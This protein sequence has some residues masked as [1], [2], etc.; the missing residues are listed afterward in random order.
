M[1]GSILATIGVLIVATNAPLPTSFDD[2][3]VIELFAAEPDIVTPTAIS[4]DDKGNPLVIECHTHFRPAGYEGPVADRLRRFE[5]TNCDG[6]ADRITTFWEGST[7][8]MGIGRHPMNGWTYVATRDCVFR[9]RDADGDGSAE[10]HE[11]LVTL[12]SADKYP[13]S[14]ISGLAFN[15]EGAVFFCFGENHAERFQMKGSDGIALTGIEGGHIYRMMADGS[16]LERVAIGCWNP[17]HLAFDPAGRL[18]TVDNDPDAL[19]PC[20]LLHIVD[21]GD[22]GYKYRN[23]RKGTHPFTAWNGELPGTL[24]MVAGTGEAPSGICACGMGDRMPADYRGDLL[25]TSWGDHRIERYRL[26]PRGAS[27]AAERVNLVTGDENFRPVGIVAG[28]DGALY[29][30]DWVDKSYELHKKGRIWRLRTIKPGD[31]SQPPG[32]EPSKSAEEQRAE[33]LRTAD[34]ATRPD[35]LW[36]ACEE[37]DP[38]IQ[39]A[40]RKG[41]ARVGAVVPTIQ[42]KS[43]NRGQ[44][45]AAA[46]ILRTVNDA[47]SQSR[48]PEFLADPDP[49]LRFVALQWA[50]EEK[51]ASCRT[52]LPEVLKAG[53]VTMRLFTGYL[54]ACEKLDRSPRKDSD[55]WTSDQYLADAYRD[56]HLPPELE[57]MIVRM[58]PPDHAV[59][60]EWRKRPDPLSKADLPNDLSA[61]AYIRS[62]ADASNGSTD[63]LATSVARAFLEHAADTAATDRPRLLPE[64]VVGLHADTPARVVRL[65]RLAEHKD[66]QVVVEALKSLRGA[67]LDAEQLSRIRQSAARSR[68]LAELAARVTDSTPPLSIPVDGNL[69]AWLKLLDGPANA[70]AGERIF[71]HPKAAQ[72]GRCHQVEGRG[73][74]IGPDLTLTGR[75]L[76]RRR[77]VESILQPSKEI[78]PQFANWAIQTK[79]GQLLTGMLVAET[80]KGEHRY[81]DSQGNIVTLNPDAIESRKQ[82][83]TSIMPE[84]LANQ[85]TPQEFRDLVA[86][87]QS[88]GP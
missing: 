12:E 69:D 61:L 50:G 7:A 55:E 23:G 40:A 47:A 16:N 42:L 80:T 62:A 29:I 59:L 17:F 63:S 79:D 20:R 37:A 75:K 39:Q 4:V 84:G 74:R 64:I 1:I 68:A 32:L 2:R 35:V 51:V 6:K 25:V 53:A 46:L 83:A 5:D 30:T 52:S 45:L 85:L 70:E 76:D 41:L 13:H 36:D 26:M 19:P 15:T 28:G 34:A 78:A 22:Y 21:G 9:L 18:F 11:P 8:T 44:R 49:D 48:L 66:D 88:G 81:A 71:Y 58:L 33:S 82:L 57:A 43:F 56:S 3:V 10:L 72:C 86:F 14:G 27:V 73:G 77:L 87:L 31:A 54:A 65:V 24:P 60:G 67:T 38:F